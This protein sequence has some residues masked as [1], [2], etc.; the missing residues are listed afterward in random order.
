MKRLFI[1][2]SIVAFA[3]FPMP[4]YALSQ[5]TNFVVSDYINAG[6]NNNLL[7][8]YSI[9]EEPGD[10]VYVQYLLVSPNDSSIVH[11]MSELASCVWLDTFRLDSTIETGI[12]HVAS[13]FYRD[14]LGNDTTLSE[15]LLNAWGFNTT[16][17]IINIPD[18]DPPQLLSAT[19]E[20]GLL[21]LSNESEYSYY[22]N[23]NIYLHIKDSGVGVYGVGA[24]YH[25]PQQP[26]GTVQEHIVG[27]SL[28]EGDKYDGVW[29]GIFPACYS[30]SLGI[31]DI[32]RIQ[33]NDRDHNSRIYDYTELISLEMNAPVNVTF[34]YQFDYDSPTVEFIFLGNDTII[35]IENG[36]D[37]IMS[38]TL[39]SDYVGVKEISYFFT[40][41][42]LSNNIILHVPIHNYC[43]ITPFW[44]DGYHSVY[45]LEYL[46]IFPGDMLGGCWALN[47]CSVTDNQNNTT[48]LDSTFF[49]Q[50]SIPYEFFV[51]NGTVSVSLSYF[52]AERQGQDVLI[53]WQLSSDALSYKYFKIYRESIE[54]ITHDK[55]TG[56]TYYEFI[57]RSAPAGETKYFLYEYDND[58][59]VVRHG[60]LIVDATPN[61]SLVLET[62]PNPFNPSVTIN[63]NIPR[64]SHVKLT[65]FNVRVYVFKT[66][67]TNT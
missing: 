21:E 32:K 10:I 61:I 25:S 23:E 63:Y 62:R 65:V 49:I 56:F 20:D 2:V 64:P 8:A 66:F 60:P 31:W 59:H 15:Y 36:P 33:L 17:E 38:F 27:F 45:F 50:H 39:W 47:S 41:K 30:S 51:V 14:T 3:T 44:K 34:A 58:N 40:H 43:D 55:F 5:L 6:S 35:N 54:L 48:V 7:T 16:I 24:T 1:I 19:S 26:C 22:S 46:Y 12:W 4:L 18:S 67:G 42:E 28:H 37:S 9:F 53:R 11:N 29:R 57:D 52:L 13:L